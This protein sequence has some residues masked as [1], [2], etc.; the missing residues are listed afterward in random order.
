MSS[1][2]PLSVLFVVDSMTSSDS[3]LQSNLYELRMLVHLL[4]L[5]EGSKRREFKRLLVFLFGGEM[6][7]MGED[8]LV[9]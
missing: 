5:D 1:S 7:V 6:M 3:P 2:S 8:E 4:S 9:M